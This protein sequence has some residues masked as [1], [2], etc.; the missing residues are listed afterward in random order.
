MKDCLSICD[1]V[2]SLSHA[3]RYFIS[4]QI[5]TL[6]DKHVRE[7]DPYQTVNIFFSEKRSFCHERSSLVHDH[8]F[9]SVQTIDVLLRRII[10]ER[11]LM[12]P[13][14]LSVSLI[15]KDINSSW[16]SFCLPNATAPL[17]TIIHSRPPFW[18]S[19]TCS[20]MDAKRP[21]AK[22]CSSSL[23]I[24]ALPNFTT[25]RLVYVSWLRS[26]NIVGLRGPSTACNSVCKS[27]RFPLRR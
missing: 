13:P 10:P 25:K 6:E 7:K 26:L 1:H 24:T 20:T 16:A 19:A 21:S 17:V 4:R 12:C 5:R 9:I 3:T 14:G 8:T 15:D 18:H 11:F 22:P 23:V 2:L 27:T